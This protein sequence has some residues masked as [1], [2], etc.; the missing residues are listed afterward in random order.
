MSLGVYIKNRHSAGSCLA[1]NQ[2]DKE[3]L[4]VEISLSNVLVRVCPDCALKL[5]IELAHALSRLDNRKDYP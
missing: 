3:P 5:K 4:V 2:P 1:C